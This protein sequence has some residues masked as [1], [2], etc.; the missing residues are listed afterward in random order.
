[1]AAFVDTN[2]L[3]Y[4]L[5][6]TN[7]GET[8]KV[9]AAKA[10]VGELMEQSDLVLSAQVLSEFASVSMRKGS[11]PLSLGDVSRMIE[12]LL[13]HPVLPVDAP[14][15]QAALQRVQKSRISYWDALIVE[16]AVRAG[17][18]VLYTEDLHHGVVYDGVEVRNPFQS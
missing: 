6:S 7:Q 15:V 3:L 10:L 8:D 2:I 9:D 5:S 4:A 16:A 17:A 13:A 14:L 12:D 11:P 18:S 1:M